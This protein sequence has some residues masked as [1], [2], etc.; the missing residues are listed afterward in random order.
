MNKIPQE[1]LRQKENEINKIMEDLNTNKTTR[2]L[3]NSEGKKLEEKNFENYD[4]ENKFHLGKKLQITNNDFNAYSLNKYF[5]EV[6]N[7]SSQFNNIGIFSLINEKNNTQV[8]YMILHRRIKLGNDN[9]VDNFFFQ[10]VTELI[11]HKILEIEESNAKQK[12]FAKISHEFKTPLNS[13]IGILI[14]N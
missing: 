11:N 13:I 3:N 12:V 5:N 7:K 14:K 10:D 2:K 1:N 9:F 4:E 6:N 8:I